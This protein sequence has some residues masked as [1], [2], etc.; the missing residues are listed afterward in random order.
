MN[1]ATA[2]AAVQIPGVLRIMTDVIIELDHRAITKTRAAHTDAMYG[3][4]T[5]PLQSERRRIGWLL[6]VKRS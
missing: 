5:L 4:W 2:E 6:P 1:S 3:P